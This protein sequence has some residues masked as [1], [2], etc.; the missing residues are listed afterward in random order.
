MGIGGYTNSKATTFQ[1]LKALE[2]QSVTSLENTSKGIKVT[3]KRTEG[4]QGYIL[5]GQQE[6]VHSK[7]LKP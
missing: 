2:P 4:V 1:I 3:W 5:Y 6:K 7:K